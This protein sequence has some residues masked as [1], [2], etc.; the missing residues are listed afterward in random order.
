M[1]KILYDF[2]MMRSHDGATQYNRSVFNALFESVKFKGVDV[3]IYCL[4]D[5]KAKIV[6]PELSISELSQYNQISFVDINSG[7][8]YVNSL[9]CDVFFLACAQF[10][11][12]YP[13]LGKME[14]KS[15][16]VFH[17][18]VWEDTYNND[19]SIYMTLNDEDSF[20]YRGTHSLG[21]MS[22]FNLKSPTWRFCRWLLYSR[23]HGKLERGYSYLHAAKKLINRR[24]DNIII[25]V[26]NYSSHSIA[27]NCGFSYDRMKVLYSPERMYVSRI[28][29]VDV[30]RNSVLDSLIKGSIK[31]YLIVS[32]NRQSKNARKV[33]R[34]FQR[35]SESHGDALIVT[36]GL[37]VKLFE[38]HVDLPFL[39]DLDLERAYKYCYALIYPSYFEGFGY[40]PLEAMKCGKPV[41]SSN[42]CS[43]PE[44]LGDAPIYFSPFFE[45]AIYGAL[46]SL[47]EETYMK[48]SELSLERYKYIS[49]KQKSDL[50]ELVSLLVDCE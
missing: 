31:F 23:R 45:S 34:V 27:Y 29:E 25:T 14:C 39:D 21:V 3:H 7:M 22:Y 28:G 50:N 2:L 37:G 32:A 33:L 19:L 48:Y 42:V 6:F 43:M 35:Y 8:D 20:R 4:Y 26:S 30:K 11:S 9:C 24:S 12:H 5:S 40:P 46:V 17:D 1:K 15:I 49:E 41:L 18:C 10:A 44:I 38:K 36:I 47:N 16:V 13:Q